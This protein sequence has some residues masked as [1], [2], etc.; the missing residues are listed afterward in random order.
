MGIGSWGWAS[1]ALTVTALHGCGAPP[2][3]PTDPAPDKAQP[4]AAEPAPPA[5]LDGLAEGWNTIAPG[6]ETICSDGSP[7]RFFVR[8]GDP[9][10]LVLYFQGG[11]AC[12]VG[13]NCDP[14][15]NPSYKIAVAEDEPARH[16]GI[17]DF[18]RLENPFADYSMVM[19]PYCTADVHLGNS[20]VDYDAPRSEDHEAHTVT[21]HH[22][23]IVNAQAAL[24]WTYAHFLS[25]AE[26]FV[27]GS[28][29]GAIPSPYYT[30]LIA[31]AYPQARIAQLGDGAGGYRRD[32]EAT[33][34]RMS[35]WGTLEHLRRHP[36]FA[37]MTDRQFTY[38][39][40]YIA[41][42]KRHPAVLFAEYDAAEDSVQKRF[43][44][45]GGS[46]AD[47]L[48][49]LLRANHADIRAEVDNFRVYIAG[50]DS[51]TILARPE[52]YSFHVGGVRIRDWVAALARFEPVDDVTCGT[53]D[54][55]EI[56]EVAPAP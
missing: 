51:H 6:G 50:G 32:G 13:D 2:A 19:V 18:A 56:L 7:Y 21:I 49:D 26:I 48:L 29:A 12:W 25:P 40:L 30:W 10:R 27:S 28:S 17:F 35:Q 20:V 22:K 34:G 9:E 5:R 44:A 42:A 33:F 53:C 43:L 38:E 31:D 14:H 55:A 11:G 3:L 1:L 45:M 36:E 23:G 39:S 8:P 52:F 46:N 54:K 16:R 41:A 4:V 47:T 24:D 37:A 15:L